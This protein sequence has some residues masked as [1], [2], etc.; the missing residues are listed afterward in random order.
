MF[1]MLIQI[2]TI[3]PS[4]LLPIPITLEVNI[5]RGI[6]FH[7]AGNVHSSIKENRQRIQVATRRAK[8]MDTKG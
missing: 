3:Q 2:R 8:K 6:K 4:F 5:S 1:S 7:I